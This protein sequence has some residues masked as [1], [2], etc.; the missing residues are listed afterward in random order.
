MHTCKSEEA[1]YWYRY[2]KTCTILNSWD[3]TAHALNGADKDGDLVMLTDNEVL[4]NKMKRLPALMCVQR[5]AK[6]IIPTDE[7]MI[8]ANIDSFGDDI[9]KTTNWITS[10]FDVQAQFEKGSP[11]YKEL[12]YR[13]KCGQLFQQ[14]AIDR[15]KGII[16]KPMPKE[17][18]DRHAVDAIEDPEK[19]DFYMRIVADKKPYFMKIIYPPLM[20]KYKN[21]IQTTNKNALREF[22]LSVNEL[23]DIPTEK[24]T[25]EQREFLKYYHKKMPVGDHDCVMNKICKRF[26]QEFDSS[27][28]RKG[29]KKPFDYSI[30]KSDVE[31]TRAQYL[32]V[33]KLY[34]DYTLR[35]REHR[36]YDAYS[37]TDKEESEGQFRVWREEFVERCSKACPNRFALCN[38][39]LDICY[40]KNSSKVFAWE[41]CGTEIIENLLKRHDYKITYPIQDEDGD[42][43]FGGYRF[44]ERTITLGGEI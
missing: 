14:N 5:K 32:S 19:K 9:G 42:I 29:A 17:W 26:E 40:K 24:L 38:I 4:V 11:E 34:D 15:A 3:T 27:S 41:M 30:M 44:S 36:I 16:S 39:I 23:L 20:R 8:K 31:Y 7:D 37:R 22:G 13:I 25:D 12:D 33:L 35:L 10:M 1:Q 28:R 43:L 21:Y 18:H 2:M 6:A